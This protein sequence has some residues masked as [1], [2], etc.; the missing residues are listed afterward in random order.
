M[1]RSVLVPA[2]PFAPVSAQAAMSM[3]CSVFLVPLGAIICAVIALKQYRDKADFY[4]GKWMAHAG[5]V[6]GIVLLLAGLIVPDVGSTVKPVGFALCGLLG[7][8]AVVQLPFVDVVLS[9]H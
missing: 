9:G 4:C 3:C 5:L 7:L 1:Q 6:I 8:P 2:I